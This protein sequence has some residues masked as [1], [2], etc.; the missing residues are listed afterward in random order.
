[1]KKNSLFYRPDRSRLLHF[2]GKLFLFLFCF[3]FFCSVLFFVMFCFVLFVLLFIVLFCF[4]FILFCFVLFCFVFVLIFVL[5]FVLF[6]FCFVFLQNHVKSVLF[7]AKSIDLVEL[8]WSQRILK[9]F[10]LQKSHHFFF[11]FFRILMISFWPAKKKKRKKKKKDP[12]NIQWLSSPFAHETNK[13]FLFIYFFFHCMSY[14][15][16]FEPKICLKCVIFKYSFSTPV[17]R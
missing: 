13:T 7:W 14:L 1:M 17:W 10:F 12:T 9:R 5:F 15:Q 3:D 4:C 11:F 2:W 16:F 8:F 6:I